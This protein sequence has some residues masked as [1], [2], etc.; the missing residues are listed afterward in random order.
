MKF[1]IVCDESGTN[2]RHLVIGA[3]IIPRINHILLIEE[4]KQLK[5]KLNLR[6]EGEVKWKK[7]SRT[8][9][10]KYKELLEWFFTHLKSNHYRFRAH[11]IDTCKKEYREYGDGDKETSFY[12]VFYHLLMR[13]IKRLAIEEEGSN[14][15]ILLDDKTNR[16]PFRLEKLKETLNRALKRDL[17]ISNLIANVEYRVSSGQQPEGLIQIVDVLIGAIGHVRNGC[18]KVQNASQ[19]KQEMIKHIEELVQAKLEYDT[20]AAAAF[21]IWTFDVG[22]SLSKKMQYKK[23]DRSRT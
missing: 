2:S 21:N 11:V 18:S 7:I 3:L 16:Y 8:Y 22:V 15:L 6:W 5:H 17:K 4:L 1:T 13:C 20:H 19:A 14:I 9:L 23:Q 10:P 12:K